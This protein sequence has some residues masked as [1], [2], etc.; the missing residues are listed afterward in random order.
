MCARATDRRIFVGGGVDRSQWLVRLIKAVGFRPP[1]ALRLYCV[2]PGLRAR[3]R[4]DSIVLQLYVMRMRM[5][6]VAHVVV[7][8]L[9]TLVTARPAEPL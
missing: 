8:G 2:G 1:R 4:L 3:G 7:T 5:W 9:F 6:H